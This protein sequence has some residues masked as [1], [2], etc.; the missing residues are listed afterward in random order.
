MPEKIRQKYEYLI[1]EHPDD[2]N[3][4]ISIDNF[5]KVLTHPDLNDIENA[6]K[7]IKSILEV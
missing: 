2:K 4:K 3:I 6:K 5:N 1:K 7:W